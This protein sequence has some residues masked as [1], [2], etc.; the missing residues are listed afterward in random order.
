MWPL[1]EQ[2]MVGIMVEST[3]PLLR[4]WQ[5]YVEAEDGVNADIRVDEDLRE[6][7]ADVISR[8]SFGSSNLR[9]KEIFAKLRSLQKAISNQS[10]LFGA[11]NFAYA[12][13]PF[14]HY[15]YI[16][17]YILIP[18]TFVIT[19]LMQRQIFSYKEA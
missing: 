16:I 8:A 11:T 15:H 6:V 18:A 2:G 13:F 4:K 12:C 10:F 14:N 5:D 9:G 19:L 17:S 7:S 3:Q 1:V